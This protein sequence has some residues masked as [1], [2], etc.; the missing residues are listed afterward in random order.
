[1]TLNYI[2]TEEDYLQSRLFISSK[3]ITVKR[4]RKKSWFF[5]TGSF[6]V[7]SMVSFL[8]EDKFLGYY[9]LVITILTLLFYP[10]YQK[11][12]YKRHYRKFVHENL[13]HH[14]NESVTITFT[15]DSVEMSD[16]TGF[17]HINI[18]E[19]DQITE[20]EKY[21]Y[22]RTKSNQYLIIPKDRTN[23]LQSVKA[24]FVDL[25]RKLNIEFIIELDWKWR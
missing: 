10:K 18:T 6:F 8:P 13:K 12:V 7:A 19:I 20:I 17:T 22:L 14:F 25:A 15:T 4:T 5:L 3:N 11:G 16:K 24:F 1:M 2:V 23:D 9:L 21:F